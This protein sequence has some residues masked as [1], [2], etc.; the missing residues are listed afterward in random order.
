MKE[1]ILVILLSVFCFRGF[2]QETTIQQPGLIKSD[3]PKEYSEQ[4]IY[5]NPC[6]A[7]K[8]TV[9]SIDSEIDEISI[10]NIAG[11]QVLLK[12]FPIPENKK[13]LDL[14]EIPDGIYLVKIK[15]NDKKQVVKKLIVSKE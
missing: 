3:D 11:K 15:T 8:I 2:T 1:I 6:K 10:T 5:P 14:T 12:K 4:K 7:G 9:E 13:Q